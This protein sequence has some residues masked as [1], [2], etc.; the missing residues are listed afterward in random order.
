MRNDTPK[1]R[2]NATRELSHVSAIAASWRT[3]RTWYV[4][5]LISGPVSSSSDETPYVIGLQE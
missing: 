3:F 1:M 2:N 4:M 5:I